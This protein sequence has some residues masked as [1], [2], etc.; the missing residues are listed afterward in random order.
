MKQ[1]IL[2]SCVTRDAYEYADQS[3]W[4]IGLYIARQSLTSIGHSASIPHLDAYQFASPFQNRLFHGDLTGNAVE[5]IKKAV[6]RHGPGDAALVLDLIDERGGIYRNAAGAVFTRSSDGGAK[7][8]YSNLPHGWELHGFGSMTHWTLYAEAAKSLKS[9][10]IEL[11]IWDRTRVI[12][13][14]WALT[15]VD[16]NETPGSMGFTADTANEVLAGYY[17]LLAEGGWHMVD[18]GVTPI[19]DPNQRWGLAPFHYT[20]EYYEAINCALNNSFI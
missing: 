17:H 13:A 12:K 20:R 15:D 11:G 7:D 6:Q 19:A 18:P 10:L 9:A 14:Q 2:G 8:V 3:R 5:E 1:L 16:G 4:Q